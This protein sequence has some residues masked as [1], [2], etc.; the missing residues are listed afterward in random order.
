[1]TDTGTAGTQW[2]TR[3]L[4]G[5]LSVGLPWQNES[6]EGGKLNKKFFSAGMEEW[7]GSRSL[8]EL[9]SGYARNHLLTEERFWYSFPK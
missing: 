7:N 3:R 6:A 8:I 9:G 1:M 2:R 5:E 4:C